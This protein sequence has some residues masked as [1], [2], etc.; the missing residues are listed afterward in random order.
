MIT[1]YLPLLLLLA[2]LAGSAGAG[3]WGWR[4]GA[5]H[6]R[7]KAAE[8]AT[9]E[10]RA[11]DAASAAAAKSVSRIKVKNETIVQEVR[12]EIQN[13]PVYRDCVHPAGQLQRINAALGA[14]GEPE[15]AGNGQ[16]PAAGAAAGSELRRDDREADRSGNPV[17]SVPGSTGA[18]PVAPAAPAAAAG[19]GAER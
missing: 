2:G 10:S 3:L 18:G 16:L 11:I 4:L 15:P 5:E 9:L 12:H 7:G 17:P 6:E 1:A 14:V 13:Q 8:Q 19:Q